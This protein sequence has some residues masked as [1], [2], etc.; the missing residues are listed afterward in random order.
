MTPEHLGT[1]VSSNDK[2]MNVYGHAITE[3]KLHSTTAFTLVVHV[4]PV[5]HYHIHNNNQL[6]HS[7]VT[8]II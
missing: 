4:L 6:V 8:L 5:V 2:S 3:S 7:P 1:L